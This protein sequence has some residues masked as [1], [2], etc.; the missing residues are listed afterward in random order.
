M[1]FSEQGE[2]KDKHF[3]FGWNFSC[4][5]AH[6]ER[7]R[8]VLTYRAMGSVAGPCGPVVG[9]FSTSDFHRFFATRPVSSETSKAE[10]WSSW[11]PL[12]YPGLVA[13]DFFWLSE[14]A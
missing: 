5:A 7:A 8:S 11:R 9:V 1:K 14:R 13:H 12:F 10:Q 3:S 2:V 4:F 6:F